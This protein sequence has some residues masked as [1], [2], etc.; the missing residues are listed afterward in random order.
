VTAAGSLPV[1]V[2]RQFQSGRKL[3]KTHQNMLVFFKGD[4]SRIGEEFGHI[5]R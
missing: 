5:Q 2:T 4:P 1:R 3:G